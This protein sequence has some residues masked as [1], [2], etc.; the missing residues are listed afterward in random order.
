MIFV[1]LSGVAKRRAYRKSCGEK[2]GVGR[3]EWLFVEAYAQVPKH[4][5]EAQA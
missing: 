1:S 4:S 3:L 2:G 5:R